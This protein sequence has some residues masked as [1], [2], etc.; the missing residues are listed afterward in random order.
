MFAPGTGSAPGTKDKNQNVQN[1]ADAAKARAEASAQKQK[2]DLAAIRDKG[3]YAWAQEVKAEKIKEKIEQEIKAREGAGVKGP[4]ES[5]PTTWSKDDAGL[6]YEAIRQM[7]EML[8]AALKS[9]SDRAAA[10]GEPAKAMVI[11]ISV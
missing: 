2:S 10:D 3:I 4:D 11:D 8:E 6:E 1:V 9:E 5:D 7:R